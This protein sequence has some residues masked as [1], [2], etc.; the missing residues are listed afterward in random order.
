MSD[1]I[2]VV[3]LTDNPDPELTEDARLAVSQHRVFAGGERHRGIVASILP[4]D[5]D[6]ITIKPPIGK[7]LVAF[8][9]EPGPILAFTSG[10]PLFY[11]FGATLQKAFPD[12]VYTYYPSFHSLQLLAHRCRM[13]YQSMRYA[14]LTGR[15]WQE[16]DCALIEGAQLIGVLTDRRK[17]PA[18]VA[19]RMLDFGFSEYT[20]IVGEALGGAEERVCEYGLEDAVRLSFHELN[21]IILSAFQPHVKL[22]GIPD[23]T[24]EGLRGRPNMITKMPVRLATLS[25]LGLVNARNFWDIGFCTGSVSVEARLLFPEIDITAFEKRSECSVLLEHNSKKCSAPG[26]RQVMGDFFLQ[27]HSA[28][29]GD[30]ETVD[31]V[32]IGGHG[33]R[34]EEMFACIDPLLSIGGRVVINAVQS[35]SLEQFHQQAGQYNYRIFEDMKIAVD[36]FN[37]ITVAAAEKTRKA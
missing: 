20:M 1:R 31:A 35:E 37:V 9:E 29:T 18:V 16:L 2:T 33:G 26:I 3:G 14:S 10:D 5:S 19:K 17:T 12:A 30:Q 32:F 7:V 23:S 6:W 4:H 15:G 36:E 8:K 34:L 27:E 22:F 25:R 28:Y 21:C 13:P 24:F 11:G